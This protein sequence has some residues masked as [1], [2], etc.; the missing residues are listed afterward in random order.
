MSAFPNQQEQPGARTRNSPRVTTGTI[1]VNVNIICLPPPN[2]KVPL[3]MLRPFNP[4]EQIPCTCDTRHYYGHSLMPHPALHHPHPFYHPTQQNSSLPFI[5]EEKQTSAQP[6]PETKKSQLQQSLTPTSKQ[7]YMSNNCEENDS[8]IEESDAQDSADDLSFSDKS[9][10]NYDS[11]NGKAETF[12]NRDN[13]AL[14]IQSLN[15][16]NGPGNFESIKNLMFN[17][18][19]DKLPAECPIGF[20]SR[21]LEIIKVFL[22]KKLVHDKKK[23]K[24]YVTIINLK[25]FNLLKFM[26]TNPPLNRKNIIKSNIFKRVWKILEKKRGLNFHQYYFGKMSKKFSKENF[27]IRN[28]RKNHCFNLG[29]EFYTRCFSSSRFL[30]DFFDCLNKSSLRRSILEQSKQKFVNCYDSWYSEI[31]TFLDKVNKPFERYMKLPDFKYGMSLAD[32]DA[33][34]AL[35]EKLLTTN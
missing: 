8:F 13:E 7:P 17:Y 4:Y 18:F 26:R 6:R 33:S 28:Y 21:E 16:N 27:S 25:S 32:L 35:F 5:S 34:V 23:S 29:D 1:N 20:S 3:P 22:I 30:S 11:E 24:T 2:L 9:S 10:F 12:G 14:N 15:T 19:F 31:K